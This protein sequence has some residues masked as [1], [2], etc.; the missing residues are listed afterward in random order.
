MKKIT[1]LLFFFCFT[2]AFSQDGTLD[3]T[4]NP[5]DT[6]HANGIDE[7]GPVNKVVVQPDGKTIMVGSF[8]SFN[9]LSRNRIARL[10]T[11]GT[12][13]TTF[14]V[15]TGATGPLVIGQTIAINSLALQ[16]DGKIIIVG[17]FRAYNGT[18][19]N[20]IARLNQDGTLDTTFNTGNGFNE[21]TRR[22]SMQADGKILV[23]GTFTSFNG[24]SSVRLLR[25]NSTGSL[26]MSFSSGICIGFSNINSIIEQPDGN[27]LIAG[28]FSTYNGL[29]SKGLA[30]LNSNG[31][32]NNTLNIGV[33]ATGLILDM[34]LLP[35]NQI[36]IVGSISSFNSVAV[37]DIARINTNGTVDPTFNSGSGVDLSIET[38]AVQSDGKIVIAGLFNTY[39]LVP[40]LNI[41][42]LNSDATLD[43]T[44]NSAPT[45]TTF[46][47][48]QTIL[49]VAIQVDSKI[50]IGGV[51]SNYNGINRN[52]VARINSDGNID[53]GFAAGTAAGDVVRAI[54]L[55]PD[56]KILIAGDFTSYSDVFKRS[57]T[58]LETNGDADPTFNT[59]AGP[60]GTVNTIVLQP[61]GKIIISGSFTFF[62]NIA[63]RNIARLNA[64]GT[65]D[66][67]FTSPIISSSG[68]F[69]NSLALQSDGKI[70]IG[71]S[72]TLSGLFF[73]TIYRL[74][75]D[76]TVDTT[77]NGGQTPNAQVHCIAMQSD[78]KILIG[79]FFTTFG[80]VSRNSIA[81]LEANGVLD[82][83]FNPGTGANNHIFSVAIQA[84]GKIIVGGKFS[85]F[86]NVARG[87][88]ARLNIDGTLDPSFNVTVVP[89]V[90]ITEVYTIALTAANKII[91][92][93]SFPPIN[94][95]T[96]NDIMRLNNDGSNDATFQS[97]IGV[98]GQVFAMDLQTDGKVLIGGDFVAY[99]QV[100]KNNIARIQNSSLPLAINNVRHNTF[101][102]FPNPS[103]GIFNIQTENSISNANITVA[104]LNG[105]IVH[106]TKAENLESKSLDLSNL[107]NGIYILNVSNGDFN[108][109]QKI[110]KQ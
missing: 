9:G 92:G 41:A 82:L 31:T 55:Q 61:D 35:N 79:G 7:F 72:F 101:T 27:I 63:R 109:S 38:V 66:T 12:L 28:T 46:P 96:S 1:H 25:L 15:G 11:D 22:V 10:N 37:S 54:K 26:D 64:D 60:N 8:I 74:N 21:E 110:V 68:S 95:A 83:S 84:D 77:F 18:S 107:Q 90:G 102:I 29:A 98:N 57:V 94:G 13:D 53:L 99:N 45:V 97:G 81:R 69:V 49:S 58:R 2:V 76:G 56:G 51:F 70:V 62:K 39:N 88:V 30:R 93:G 24:V 86:D 34:A 89:T 65:L 73:R 19:L 87:R 16:S 17:N 91:V 106:E 48:N 52:Y 105:R 75:A 23:A 80:G 71:G 33:G 67:S 5:T 47:T 40:R 14:N 50:V 6:G 78:G 100:G 44:F 59:G 36:I 103:T 3:V 32:F 4:F 85:I 108:H 20:R 104:D 43:L 42:R